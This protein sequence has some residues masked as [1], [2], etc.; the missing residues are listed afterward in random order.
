MSKYSNSALVSVLLLF[1]GLGVS[2]AQDFDEVVLS[3]HTVSG[4]VSYIEGRGGNIGLFTGDDGVFLIDDQYAPLTDKIVTAIRTLSNHPIRFLVNTHMHPDHTGGNENFGRM[5]TMIFGHDN[6]RTQMEIAGYAEQPPLITFSEDMSFHIN[7]ET[8]HVLKVPDAHTN[9]DAF[10][11]FKG[12]N[13]V[14]TGDV[15]RTT[16]YPYIDVNNG[17]SFLGTIEALNLLI[18]I[19]DSNTKIIPGHGGISNVDEV[20][21]FRDMLV[22]IRDRVAKAIREGAS[23]DQIQSGN[24]TAEYD[25]RWDGSG[26]IGGSASMLAA[27]YQDLMN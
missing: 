19:S 23:L 17:G 26:R 10:V 13:V 9:G 8:V 1:L 14:H 12:S 18:D 5:G 11:R 22:V 3:I 4:N 21:A 7:G 24:L 20:T 25:E 15:Y 27:V 16:T 6:V 2:L